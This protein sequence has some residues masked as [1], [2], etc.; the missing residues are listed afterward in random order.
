MKFLS[1][2]WLGQ[3]L[4]NG[5]GDVRL[6]HVVFFYLALMIVFSDG[7]LSWVSSKTK[8]PFG[9]RAIAFWSLFFIGATIAVT[10]YLV[11]ADASFACWEPLA[12]T[13]FCV[14]LRLVRCFVTRL[15]YPHN[16]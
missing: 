2:S 3:L 13:G 15:F 11:R 9:R 1:L 10:L 5:R 14:L 7:I 16:A 12:L 6:Y 4:T 8:R